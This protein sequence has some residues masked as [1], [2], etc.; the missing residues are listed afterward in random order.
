MKKTHFSVL[1]HTHLGI[2]SA[3]TFTNCERQPSQLFFCGMHEQNIPLQ[4]EY[5]H[6]LL[7]YYR[8][9]GAPSFLEEGL[10]ETS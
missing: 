3:Y 1:V 4:F 6:Q 2:W 10:K 7:D 9:K 5:V 8:C